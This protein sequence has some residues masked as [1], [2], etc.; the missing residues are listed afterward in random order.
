MLIVGTLQKYVLVK[1]LQYIELMVPGRKLTIDEIIWH[2][3]TVSDK[4]GIIV[5]GSHLS[6]KQ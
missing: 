4:R 1:F 3:C 5:S 2:F 6:S